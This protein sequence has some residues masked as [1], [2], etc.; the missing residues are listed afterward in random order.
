MAGPVDFSAPPGDVC[1]ALIGG[2]PITEISV[3]PEEAV[4][5]FAPADDQSEIKWGRGYGAAMEG[6]TAIDC[7]TGTANSEWSAYFGYANF[8]AAGHDSL[9][10]FIEQQPQLSQSE[11]DGRTIYRYMR[12]EYEPGRDI[13]V[14]V[15]V[16]D[17][18]AVLWFGDEMGKHI[19]DL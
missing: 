13:P 11:A 16:S 12:V 6:Q 3:K 15:S 1:R 10:S 2:R 8:D 14:T 19:I 4:A 5:E 17:T 9:V 18:N 7:R